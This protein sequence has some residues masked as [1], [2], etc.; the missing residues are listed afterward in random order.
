MKCFE[1][2][3]GFKGVN[4]VYTVSARGNDIMGGISSSSNM[5]Y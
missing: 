5:R 2:I 4:E 3:K 1:C